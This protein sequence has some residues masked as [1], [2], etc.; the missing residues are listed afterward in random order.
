MISGQISNESAN[1]HFS[2]FHILLSYITLHHEKIPKKNIKTLI[3]TKSRFK[4]Y[5]NKKI[6]SLEIVMINKIVIIV[7]ALLLH[8]VE[9]F[10]YLQL[11]CIE[12]FSYHKKYFLVF[13]HFGT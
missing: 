11:D 9:K 8:P 1:L 12:N 13:T 7:G 6:F 4:N 2:N 5:E 10:L 3:T